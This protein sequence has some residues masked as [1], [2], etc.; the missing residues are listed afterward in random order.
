[1]TPKPATRIQLT[2]LLW[3]AAVALGYAALATMV[4]HHFAMTTGITTVWPSSGLALAAV[5]I[6]G[7]RFLPAVFIGALAINLMTGFP[8]GVA[9][10]IATGNTLEAFMGTWL[11][12][13]CGKWDASLGTLAD[14]L[15]LIAL[16]DMLACVFAAVNGCAALLTPA[17]LIWRHAP[18][19]WRSPR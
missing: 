18:Q 1:V 3:M 13:R 7:V 12:T 10:A 14:Y 9:T 8:G 19:G 17:L 2:T 16:G 15:K 11:L 4:L 5:L 6:G